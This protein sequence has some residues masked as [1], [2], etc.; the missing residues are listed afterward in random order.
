[1]SD[2]DPVNH[3]S[4]YRASGLEAIEVIEAFDLNYRRGNAL[5]YLLRAGR[6]DNEIQDLE[7]SIWYLQRELA[8]LRSIK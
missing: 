6:K 8:A 7:K 4:H 3:P 5:K 1:M 2:V